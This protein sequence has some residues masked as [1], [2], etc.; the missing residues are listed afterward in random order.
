MT[1]TD[2]HHTAAVPA[3]AA[4]YTAFAALTPSEYQF[5]PLTGAVGSW[6]AS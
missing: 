5:I 6:R 1:Q 3:A 2:L 4:P